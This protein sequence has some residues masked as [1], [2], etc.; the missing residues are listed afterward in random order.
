MPDISVF[1]KIKNFVKD[2]M[3]VFKKSDIDVMYGVHLLNVCTARAMDVNFYKNGGIQNNFMGQLN[4]ISI[5]VWIVHQRIKEDTQTGE[6]YDVVQ[7]PEAVVHHL[8]EQLW[9]DVEQRILFEGISQWLLRK[10]LGQVQPVIYGMMMAL[11][12][13]MSVLQTKDESE[14][15]LGGLWRNIYEGKPDL[16]RAHLTQLRDYILRELEYVMTIDAEDF[17]AGNF[18]WGPSPSSLPRRNAEADALDKRLAYTNLFSG[19]VYTPKS[20]DK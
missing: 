8:Y 2:Q 15:L 17:Y 7:N 10:Y 16:N 11:D 18:A 5:H 19:E 6:I 3:N 9:G 13:G 4:V 1:G 12:K 20:S 14:V